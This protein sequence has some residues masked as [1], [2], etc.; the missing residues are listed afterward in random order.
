MFGSRL[1]CPKGCCRAF[2]ILWCSCLLRGPR[3]VTPLTCGQQQREQAAQ[4]W[5]CLE[6]VPGAN[7]IYTVLL[8]V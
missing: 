6:E 7:W 1:L 8:Q 4:A 5:G 2:K 3:K